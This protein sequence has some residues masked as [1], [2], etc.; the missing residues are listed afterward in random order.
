VS[1]RGGAIESRGPDFRHI[2]PPQKFP[3]IRVAPELK[4]RPVQE[5]QE[6]PFPGP[7]L[8][9]IVVFEREEDGQEKG[10]KPRT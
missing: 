9:R 3:H 4:T 8:S 5:L 10:G 7:L 1:A 2:T 6:L